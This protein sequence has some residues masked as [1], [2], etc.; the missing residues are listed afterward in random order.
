M[1]K[2]YLKNVK[3]NNMYIKDQNNFKK[4]KKTNEM[5]TNSLW[6]ISNDI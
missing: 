3:N 4:V 2:T 1:R 5:F 6:I